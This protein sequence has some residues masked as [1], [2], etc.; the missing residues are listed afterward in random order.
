MMVFLKDVPT[1]SSITLLLELFCLRFLKDMFIA[2]KQGAQ[3]Y[4]EKYYLLQALFWYF[5]LP[6]VGH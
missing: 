2:A 6:N 4:F 5:E 3:V 1:N